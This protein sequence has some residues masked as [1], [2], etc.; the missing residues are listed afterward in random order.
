MTFKLRD[1]IW[2]YFQEDYV[3]LPAERSVIFDDFFSSILVRDGN[4]RATLDVFLV[5]SLVYK[6]RRISRRLPE[7][8]REKDV[9]RKK[10]WVGSKCCGIQS[11]RYTEYPIRG[12]G[13]L[14]AK[15]EAEHQGIGSV[16][17]QGKSAKLLYCDPTPP[18][19]KGC[20]PTPIKEIQQDCWKEPQNPEEDRLEEEGRWQLAQSHNGH[21]LLEGLYGGTRHF[22][23]SQRPLWRMHAEVSCCFLPQGS[24]AGGASEFALPMRLPRLRCRICLGAQAG[25]PQIKTSLSYHSVSE[26]TPTAIFWSVAQEFNGPEKNISWQWSQV[27]FCFH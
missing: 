23:R 18:K 20:H 19:E 10:V 6:L 2:F 9:L 12:Y 4:F 27:E 5:K 17:P 1:W 16:I 11:I 8:C 13:A 25:R 21:V 26:V 15:E 22:K 14:R 3:T 7:N 24:Q